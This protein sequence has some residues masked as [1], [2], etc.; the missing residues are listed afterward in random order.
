MGARQVEGVHCRV[1]GCACD[2]RQ[3]ADDALGP[4]RVGLTGGIRAP[5]GAACR[6]KSQVD[7][8][9]IDEVSPCL[10][11]RLGI[12]GRGHMGAELGLRGIAGTAP[13]ACGEA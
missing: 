2:G 7:G 6:A 9:D 10:K 8:R 3:D 12:L 11:C 4:R 5:A 1:V 13:F